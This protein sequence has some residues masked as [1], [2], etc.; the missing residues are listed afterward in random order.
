MVLPGLIYANLHIDIHTHV[1]MDMYI[2]IYTYAY[3]VTSCLR[4]IINF[5]R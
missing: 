2:Y 4:H 3:R 5:I 1:Y